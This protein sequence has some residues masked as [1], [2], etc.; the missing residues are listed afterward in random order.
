MKRFGIFIIYLVLTF[1][2]YSQSNQLVYKKLIPVSSL[3]FEKFDDGSGY[4][5]T[6][7]PGSYPAPPVTNIGIWEDVDQ[8]WLVNDT[9][10]RGLILVYNS[11]LIPER[12]MNILFVSSKDKLI[13]F[14]N[15]RMVIPVQGFGMSYTLPWGA[16]PPISNFSTSAPIETAY[17]IF[18]AANDSA[19]GMFYYTKNEPVNMSFWP[20][21]GYAWSVYGAGA[22]LNSSVILND[23]LFISYLNL[24]ENQS[25][26][27]TLNFSGYGSEINL[28]RC[29]YNLITNEIT[30]Q[31]I[32]SNSGSLAS[33]ALEASQDGNEIFRVG[34]VRGNDTPMSISGTQLEM[35]PNDSLYHVFMTKESSMGNTEWLTELYAYNNT[36]P[37]TTDFFSEFRVGNLPNSIIEDNG[38]VFLSM[39]TKVYAPYGDSL[40]YRNFL[41]NDELY[42]DLLP[43]FT[44]DS[45]TSQI[46]FARIN[47]FKLNESGTIERNLR[48]TPS[49]VSS[50]STQF[51]LCKVADKLAWVFYHN[52][53]ND[54][55]IVFTCVNTDGSAENTTIEFQS[56]RS[57]SLIWLNTDLEILDLWTIP[58]TLPGVPDSSPDYGF[59][60]N[61]IYPYHGDTL[62]IQGNIFSSVVTTL[63]PFGQSEEIS[64]STDGTSSFFAFYSAPEILTNTPPLQELPNLSIYPNPTEGQ[65]HISGIATENSRYR[66]FDISGRMVQSGILKSGYMVNTS[67]LKSGMY[68]L[69]IDSEKGSGS[70][71]FV[72]K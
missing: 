38:N 30:A 28:L 19:Y 13:L 25:L 34:M 21:P 62:L 23:T 65:L 58:Y 49:I 26:N 29:E 55:T 39:Q 2:L 63:D 64:P 68:I 56:G 10:F 15:Q 12:E 36:G 48:Y 18:D 1:P 6:C 16:N 44:F 69:R 57:V 53:A 59:S 32:G 66:I 45:T 24:T 46:P 14:S 27:N 8:N 42:Y 3:D 33:L 17:F 50:Y 43:N 61:G 4:V 40:L 51:F 41:G 54:S 11:D 22:S 47:L 72:V 52:Y 31:Q 71:K 70:R 5:L 67:S 20:F 60:I 35:V 7:Y 9:L 37:D